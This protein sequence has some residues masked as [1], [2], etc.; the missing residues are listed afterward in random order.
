MIKDRD[1]L[2]R[3]SVFESSSVTLGK[4]PILLYLSLRALQG[5]NGLLL[6][7]Y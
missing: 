1:S 6:T 4:F 7:K 5:L 3:L 2:D